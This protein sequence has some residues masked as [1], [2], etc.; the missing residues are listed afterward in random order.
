MFKFLQHQP[1]MLQCRNNLACAALF[2]IYI[3]L[4]FLPLFL[5]FLI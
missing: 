2:L 3:F 4:K 5:K 1:M